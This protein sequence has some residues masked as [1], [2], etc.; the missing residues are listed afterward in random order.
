MSSLSSLSALACEAN[1]F[2]CGKFSFLIVTNAASAAVMLL[3][4]VVQFPVIPGDTLVVVRLLPKPVPIPSSS[5][6]S[7]IITEFVPV[8][9]TTNL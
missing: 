8:A 2:A 9:L 3:A 6:G 1:L 4:S 7:L 5:S